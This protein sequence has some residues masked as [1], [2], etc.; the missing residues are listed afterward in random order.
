[1]LGL[2]AGI[3]MSNDSDEIREV[4]EREVEQL[5]EQAVTSTDPGVVAQAIA[6][7]DGSVQEALLKKLEAES[8]LTGVTSAREAGSGNHRVVFTFEPSEETQVSLVSE[9][10]M[11]LVDIEENT[12]TRVDPDFKSGSKQDGPNVDPFVLSVPSVAGRMMGTPGELAVTQR[13]QE[14]FDD[15]GIESARINIPTVIGTTTFSA[16]R[17]DDTRSD[18]DVMTI[19]TI[20][21]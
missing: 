19:E 7:T 10:V 4:L 15:L 9:G 3:T 12:V 14:F 8:R 21:V 18:R 13:E 6:A 16:G 17:A 1:M 5:R 2:T 20:Y 11:A